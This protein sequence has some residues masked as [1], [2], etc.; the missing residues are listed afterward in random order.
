MFVRLFSHLQRYRMIYL[1]NGSL[2]ISGMISGGL[3]FSRQSTESLASLDSM[4]Q[5]IL[6]VDYIKNPEMIQNNLVSNLL[7]IGVVFF[8]GLSVAGIPFLTF[9]MF[10]KGVQIGFSCM[11]YIQT[12]APK[13]V[14]GILLTLIPFIL[15]EMISFFILCA[16]AYEVSLS[17]ILATFIEK[18][19]LSLKSV[20]NHFLNYVL[21][22][23]ALVLISTLFKIY[24]MPI[25]YGLIQF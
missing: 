20:L 7:L 4:I 16:V 6:S 15:F 12:Y 13:G 22:S 24:I 8:L 19:N 5:T 10:S 23:L 11:L 17:I 25:L 21:I 14:A 2:L 3:L 1:F 18:T 9:I